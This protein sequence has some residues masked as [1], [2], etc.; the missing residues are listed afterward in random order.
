M[1]SNKTEIQKG[2]DSDWISNLFVPNLSHKFGFLTGIFEKRIV[3]ESFVLDNYLKAVVLFFSVV[4][5]IAALLSN[6]P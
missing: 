1:L 3:L 6:D 5:I 2:I 4:K